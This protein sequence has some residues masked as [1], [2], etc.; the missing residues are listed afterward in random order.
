MYE[1]W[2]EYRKGTCTFCGVMRMDEGSGRRTK[3]CAR[4]ILVSEVPRRIYGCVDKRTT[5][6]EAGVFFWARGKLQC[7]NTGGDQT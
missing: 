4:M 3:G 6:T 7:G 5:G 1:S 2:G